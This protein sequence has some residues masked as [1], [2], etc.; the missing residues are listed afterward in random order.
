M[1]ERFKNSSC[2]MLINDK[3]GDLTR[4]SYDSSVFT[5][6]ASILQLSDS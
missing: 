6:L 5:I 3:N 1:K 2:V 4:R